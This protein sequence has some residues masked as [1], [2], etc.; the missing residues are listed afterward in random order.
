M[1]ENKLELLTRICYLGDEK[2]HLEKPFLVDVDG[3]PWS[4][5]TDSKM[6]LAFAGRVGGVEPLA[7]PKE[8]RPMLRCIA[9]VI[10]DANT[11]SYGCDLDR[12]RKFAGALDRPRECVCTRCNGTGKACSCGECKCGFCDDGKARHRP[13]PRYGYVNGRY[14]DLN[15]VS[16]LLDGLSGSTRIKLTGGDHDPILWSGDGWCAVLMP[17]E[18]IGDEGAPCFWSSK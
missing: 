11:A 14:C 8:H 7:N 6:I 4:V 16:C 15:R 5:A 12:L 10:V 13:R 1:P 9:G 17:C 2:P 3:K 18:D